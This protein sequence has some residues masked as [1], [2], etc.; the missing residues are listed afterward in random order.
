MSSVFADG[1]IVLLQITN[2]VPVVQLP[3][4]FASRPRDYLRGNSWP[5]TPLISLCSLPL[6]LAPEKPPGVADICSGC[7]FL[8]SF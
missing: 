4:Y 2:K 1:V 7:S 3:K 5:V 6:N 8:F